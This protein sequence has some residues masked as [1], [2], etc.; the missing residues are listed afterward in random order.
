MEGY[1][2]VD[3]A[4]T[5]AAKDLNAWLKLARAFVETLPAK[6]DKPHKEQEAASQENG[7]AKIVRETPHWH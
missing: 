7:E 2:F 1:V 3:P 6:A 4:G 5:K